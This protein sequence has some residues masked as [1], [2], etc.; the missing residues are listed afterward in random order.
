MAEVEV[1]PAD[2]FRVEWP[3][4]G[5]L[6]SDWIERHCIV[7]D[8]FRQG[9]PF[10]L[11][12]WQLWCTLNHYR[13]KLDAAPAGDPYTD[14]D[15]ESK[16]RSGASAFHFRRS[17]VIA[18]QKA[19]KGPWSATM[20][21]AEA[22]G[23]VLFDG[24]AEAG[25]V[26]RCADHGCQCGWTYRY[27]PGEP[28]GKP[29]PKP[30]IQL[31][32]TAEDQVANVYRPL[33]AMARGPR[34]AGLMKPTE[35]FI[36]LPNDGRIDVVT[37][38][39]QARLGQP[40]V[41]ALQDESGLYTTTNKMVTVAE[42]QRRG[43]AGMG[44]R[45]METTN[46][47]DPT[48]N[49]TCQRSTDASRR[50]DDIFVFWRKSPARLGRYTVKRD[51]R[52]IHRYAY[53]GCDHVDLDDI[54]RE[55]AELILEDPAQAERFFG[56]RD[57]AGSSNWTTP[58]D[59]DRR[60]AKPAKPLP[61]RREKIVLGFD[62]SDG[63]S[64]GDKRPA[65]STV[66]RACRL[67]DGHRFTLP[68]P[69]WKDRGVDRPG[70][71]S[72]LAI[73]EH[74]RD[75][76]GRPLAEWWVPRLEVMSALDYAFREWNVVFCGVDPPYWREQ[77]AELQER[78]GEDRVVEFRTANDQLMA[79]ALDRLRKTDTTHDGDPII[80]QHAIN[81]IA[82]QKTYL[83][84]ESDQRKTITLVSKASKD[85]PDKIDGLIS[86]AI[87]LDLWHRAVAAGVRKK[88]ARVVSFG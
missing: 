57:K 20:V 37:S 65:D 29:W 14:T 25:Q 33:Q 35:D 60:L 71:D 40:I 21:C 32:A 42:T 49:S 81:A 43:V 36:R 88:S 80:R 85:S 51:R 4:L 38:S 55:A 11:Y 1:D 62:G 15:G 72:G 23:P 22:V 79:G 9:D 77:L 48:Q 39:A 78:H 76:E 67:S 46:A 31:V 75:S 56:N 82:R 63:T 16:F 52:R 84:D 53:R 8:G 30:L 5:F 12:E 61:R 66:I 58:E 54:E 83:D 17:V 64:H 44:G 68:A 27:R 18:P 69:A 3:S 6:I 74:P 34:L 41:F 26:Y 28:I 50:V 73:W 86:D 70:S 10:R 2:E 87:A 59:W 45:S 19:G 7:P 13:L 47:F 24:W